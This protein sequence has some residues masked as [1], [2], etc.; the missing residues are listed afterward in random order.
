MSLIT[1]R[2]FEELAVQDILE[3]ADVGRATFYAHFDNKEDLLVSGLETLRLSLKARQ[4]GRFLHLPPPCS[5]TRAIT[6]TCFAP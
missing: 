2:G 6:G 1:E 4:R 3:R 5:N